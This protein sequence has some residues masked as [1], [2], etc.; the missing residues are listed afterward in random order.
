[1]G[2]AIIIIGLQGSGKSTLGM[3]LNPPSL[4]HRYFDWGW[5]FPIN[6]KGEILSSFNEDERF[7]E[8]IN[9][10]KNNQDVILDS[11][12]FC[13]HKFLCEAEYY[14]NLNFPNI[15]IEKYYFENN[16]K[17][18]T[19]NVLYREANNGGYWELDKNNNLLYHG[20]HFTVEGLNFNRRFYEVIIESLQKISKNYII[21]DKYTPLSIEVQDEK[22]Y[23]GWKALIR[24]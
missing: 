10:V 14:L 19:A 7:D 20:S 3:K 15:Q 5:K 16:P 17:D 1:M 22:Y 8:L 23:Q 12:W 2:K 6:E 18:A 13:N 21:P 24:E 9:H 4:A 11:T